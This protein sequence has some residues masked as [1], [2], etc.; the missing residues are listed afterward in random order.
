MVI[1]MLDNSISKYMSFKVRCLKNYIYTID[2][3]YLE[4]ELSDKYLDIYL[5]TYINTRGDYFE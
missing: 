4:K 1:K 5:K 2:N 3:N